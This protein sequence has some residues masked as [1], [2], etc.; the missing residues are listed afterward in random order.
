MVIDFPNIKIASSEFGLSYNTTTFSSPYSQSTQIMRLPGERWMATYNFP[1]MNQAQFA[2][3]KVFLMQLQG[4]TVLFNGFDPD[5]KT[6]SGFATGIPL[7]DGANQT[8]KTLLTKGWTHSVT[9][10]L[11]AG[12]YI[13]FATQLRLDM[14]D[15]NSDPSGKATLTLDSPLRFSPADNTSIITTQASCPMRITSNLQWS[16][17]NN[18]IV[19]GFSITAIEAF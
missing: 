2:A 14:A 6:P 5:K 18:K 7:V 17:D 1:P 10:I 8:G 9:G 13:Q 16:S 12:D 11:K 15:A 3:L 4:G 19:N